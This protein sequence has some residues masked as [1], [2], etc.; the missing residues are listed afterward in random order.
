MELVDKVHDKQGSFSVSMGVN[1]PYDQCHYASIE[2]TTSDGVKPLGDINL[3]DKVLTHKGNFKEVTR[4]FKNP[5]PAMMNSIQVIGD[6]KRYVSTPN[7]P[8]FYVPRSAVYYGSG[9]RRRKDHFEQIA[10]E[11]II[12]GPATE[13]KPKDYLLRPVKQCTGTVSM[14]YD[15]AY[16]LGFYLGDGHLTWL[17]DEYT[18]D[19]VRTVPRSVDLTIDAKDRSTLGQKLVDICMRKEYDFSLRRCGKRTQANDEYITVNAFTFSIRSR[20]LAL[21]V[22]NNFGTLKDKHIPETVYTWSKEALKHFIGGYV[23]ADGCYR[24]H[25][26]ADVGTGRGTL[27]TTSVLEH[28]SRAYQDCFLSAGIVTSIRKDPIHKKVQERTVYGNSCG[29]VLNVSKSQAP[30]LEGYSVKVTLG[31][32]EVK[33]KQYHTTKTDNLFVIYEDTQYLAMKVRGVQEVETTE[34]YVYNISVADD[35]TYVADG[36]LT[37]NCSVCHNKASKQSDYCSHLKYELGKTRDD[38]TRVYAINGGYD[39]DKHP[40]A[41]NFFDI[42]YVFRPAD[43]TGYM[44]KKVA[45]HDF[46]EEHTIGSAEA[47]NKLAALQEK[48]AQLKKM[49]DITKYFEGVPFA[50]L[51]SEDNHQLKVINRNPQI[52]ENVVSQMQELTPEHYNKLSK[53]P[54]G[55]ILASLSDLGI[56]LTT[57]EFIKMVVHKKTGY[58]LDTDTL[59]QMCKDQ[60]AIFEELS[61]NPEMVNTLAAKATMFD[62][63]HKPK[64]EIKEIVSDIKDSRDLSPDGFAKKASSSFIRS[65]LG[66]HDPANMFAEDTLGVHHTETITDPATGKKYV[67]S[68]GAIDEGEFKEKIGQLALLA[69]GAGLLAGTY[70]YLQELKSGVIGPALGIGTLA[71]GAKLLY[72]KAKSMQI[73]D[74]RYTDSGMKI[75]KATPM[76]EKKSSM[77]K[78]LTIFDEI[79]K[80]AGGPARVTATLA[81][82]SATLVGNEYY[83]NRLKH[84]TAGTYRTLLEKHLDNA[85]R[86]AYEHP[87]ITAGAGTA[88][89]HMLLNVLRKLRS[90]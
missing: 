7:H 46:E 87:I 16:I 30:V 79:A 3:G 56:M 20:E 42:S 62:E 49:A 77:K 70:A 48:S 90:H 24:K 76:F 37:H 80:R 51:D 32:Q 34:D 27:T 13:V 35:E 4:L 65:N 19:R 75:P 23:D 8:V 86:V 64:E 15:E 63:S 73:D 22:H 53:Y 61:S 43:K 67:A 78:K 26:K 57:P 38:G 71:L 6:Y 58:Q 9:G 72:D 54:M 12:Y 44:L 50:Q 29:Y 89:G 2:I 18:K 31:C 10:A 28:L 74:Y 45:S 68:M 83:D 59:K 39:Y 88:G 85:G 84:G 41:L 21:E 33:P 82:G 14:D 60:S 47:F 17:Y 25:G 52:F 66:Y 40:K 69:G 5:A 55:E 36:Y 11:S 1:I 81:P